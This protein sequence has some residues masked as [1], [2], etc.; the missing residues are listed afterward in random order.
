M[1]LAALAAGVMKTETNIGCDEFD[2]FHYFV[3][4]LAGDNEDEGDEMVVT[5]DVGQQV[6]L[7]FGIK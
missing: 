5:N 1:V 4:G 3:D 2:E 7:V 6:T